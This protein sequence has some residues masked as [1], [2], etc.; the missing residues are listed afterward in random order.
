MLSLPFYRDCHSH[1][2][3]AGQRYGGEWIDA[4]GVQRCIQPIFQ[5]EN[6]CD[7]NRYRTHDKHQVKEGQS[8]QHL[9]E[10]VLPHLP[11][12]HGHYYYSCGSLLRAP[13]ERVLGIPGTQDDYGDDVADESNGANDGEEDALAPILSPQPHLDLLLGDGATIQH[14]TGCPVISNAGTVHH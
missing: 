13:T 14:H 11:E 1:V 3:A 8:Q 9:I 2:N 5:A 12:T 7:V 4:V 10:R 6:R